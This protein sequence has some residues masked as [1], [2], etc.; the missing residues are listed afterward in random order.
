MMTYTYITSSNGDWEGI[1]RKRVLYAQGRVIPG[2]VWAELLGSAVETREIDGDVMEEI[3]SLPTSLDDL[4]AEA[5]GGGP[6]DL[7]NLNTARG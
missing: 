4:Q 6:V 7:T 2:H 3:G 1:Y 5:T